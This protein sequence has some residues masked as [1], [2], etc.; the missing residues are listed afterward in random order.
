MKTDVGILPYRTVAADA[1]AKASIDAIFFGAS[2]TQ[3][4]VSEVER[5]AFRLRWLGRYLAADAEHCFVAVAE[6]GVIGYLVGALDDPAVGNRFADI[7][8]FNDLAHLTSIYPAHLHINLAPETRSQGIGARLI[9]AFAA[10]ALAKGSP[11]MHVVTG[12]ASRN[13]HFYAACGFVEVGRLETAR[14]I[15]FLGRK[16][17]VQRDISEGYS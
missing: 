8:Y 6:G 11:G 17:S 2:G 1:A 16:L 14:P 9:E 4:F 13:V 3:S 5:Q 15:V 12:A 10:H 7:G